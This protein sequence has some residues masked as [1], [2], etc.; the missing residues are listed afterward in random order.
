M[1]SPSHGCSIS[2]AWGNMLRPGSNIIIAESRLSTSFQLPFRD[3]LPTSSSE[4]G[5]GVEGA[6]VSGAGCACSI[7]EPLSGGMF[8]REG[9][10]FVKLVGVGYVVATG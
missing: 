6:N 2:M 4:S 10:G 1:K 9:A 5:P 7:S 3:I 8:I